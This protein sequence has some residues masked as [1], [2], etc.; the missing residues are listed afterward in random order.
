MSAKINILAETSKDFW[1]WFLFSLNVK[2]KGTRILL[3]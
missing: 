3:F 2:F 1:F